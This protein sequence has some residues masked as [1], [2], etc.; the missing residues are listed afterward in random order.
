MLLHPRQLISN[1]QHLRLTS[2]RRHAALTA[3]AGKADFRETVG[4][5]DTKFYCF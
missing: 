3:D 5:T 2:R 4:S 1:L